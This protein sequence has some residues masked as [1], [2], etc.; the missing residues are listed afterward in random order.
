MS[1]RRQIIRMLDRPGG[2]SILGALA[3]RYA[4]FRTK[5]DVGIF[6]DEVWAHRTGS[7]VLAD[8]D[9]FEYFAHSFDSMATEPELLEREADD[10]WFHLYKPKQ[11]DV[12]VDVGAG[13]GEHLLPFS[14]SVG[15]TGRVI[16]I[17]AHPDT[18]R[19]LRRTSELNRLS[20]VVTLNYAIAD[21][22]G[23]ML[24]DT[25]PEWYASTLHEEQGENPDARE[26]EAVT[27]EDLLTSQAL[28]AITFLKMNIEGA[29]KAALKNLARFAHR[30]SYICVACHDFRADRGEGDEYRTRLEVTRLL[31]ATGFSPVLARGEDPRPYVRDHVH[32]R[33]Q[34]KH[35]HVH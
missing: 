4:H 12:I 21:K 26:V 29:E 14:R 17:E 13:K 6:Y 33:L 24:I 5:R 15:P 31:N 23:K 28:A 30:V 35:S 27:L 20:N 25:A 32:A 34:S 18:F 3:T 2:R 10:Y 7:W 16:A 19:L 1:L 8:S 11:G 22:R 9:K